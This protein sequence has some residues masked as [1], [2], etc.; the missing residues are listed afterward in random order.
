MYVGTDNTQC[1]ARYQRDE[2]VPGKLGREGQ[3]P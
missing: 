2:E 1:D 3:L